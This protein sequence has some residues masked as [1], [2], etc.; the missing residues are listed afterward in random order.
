MSRI[1]GRITL[2]TD[3]GTADG[4]VGAMKGCLLS[5][6]PQASLCDISHSIEPQHIVQGAWCLRR[7]VPQFPPGTVHLA[8]VDPGVGSSRE[9]VIVVTPGGLL[10]GPDNGLLALVAQ[11]LGIDSVWAIQ[12]AP[13]ERTRSGSFDGLTLFAPTA[14]RLA[15]GVPPEE[16]AH[17]M[18]G[19]RPLDQPAPAPG[20]DSVAGEILFF[21]RFGNAITNIPREMIPSGARVRVRL[22]SGGVL[23][24]FSHYSAFA[25]EDGEDAPTQSGAVWNSD[26]LLEL[27]CFSGSFRQR[28]GLS[29]GAGVV[30]SWD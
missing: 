5:I 9:A 2:T 29:A 3:F 26:G 28:S 8:V 30:A 22:P 13:P 16:L 11:E 27:A 4:Y 17:P 23:R 25:G 1:T 15:L 10:V 7:S 6:S 14:A 21:D 19:L 12:E 24:V 20:E 18:S